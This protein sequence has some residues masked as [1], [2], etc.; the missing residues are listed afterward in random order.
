MKRTLAA[1]AASLIALP[2]AAAQSLSYTPTAQEIRQARANAAR[3][4]K[5]ADATEKARLKEEARPVAAYIPKEEKPR[6]EK[7]AKLAQ[8][9]VFTAI[10]PGSK[11]QTKSKQ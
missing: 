4:A 3:D 2:P 9:A 1:F 7:A 11:P 10:V 6:G 8:P 5:L